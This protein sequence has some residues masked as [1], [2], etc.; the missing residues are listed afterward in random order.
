M[1]KSRVIVSHALWRLGG[2]VALVAMALSAGCS[3]SA[4][5]SLGEVAQPAD[6]FTPTACTGSGSDVPG[7][8]VDAC[9]LAGG[10]RTECSGGVSWCCRSCTEAEGCKERCSQNPDDLA[11][12]Q[13]EIDLGP[14]PD[15]VDPQSSTCLE[16]SK[17]P[18]R[19]LSVFADACRDRGGSPSCSEDNTACCSLC[20]EQDGC[21]ELCVGLDQLDEVDKTPLTPEQEKAWSTLVEEAEGSTERQHDDSPDYSGC[22]NLCRSIWHG[23][24]D[25]TPLPSRW[26]WYIAMGCIDVCIG[27]ATVGP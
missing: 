15:R 12:S 2:S 8:F 23:C 19:D 6:N 11:R 18:G 9:T 1:S 21:H 7:D 14:T 20:T 27:N 16:P 4:Q 10:E 22:K 24:D 3:G 13:V 17:D 25:Y 5:E 26:C